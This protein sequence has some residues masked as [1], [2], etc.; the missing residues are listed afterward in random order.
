VEEAGECLKNTM[1][2]GFSLGRIIHIEHHYFIQPNRLI[3]G[4]PDLAGLIDCVIYP[5]SS[6]CLSL[7]E[8]YEQM[9][10]FAYSIE[11]E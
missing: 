8:S 11:A 4:T 3:F 9:D 7:L 5:Q 2:P 10:V 6:P 1:D